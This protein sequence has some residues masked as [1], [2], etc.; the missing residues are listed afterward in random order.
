[1]EKLLSICIPVY[2]NADSLEILVNQIRQVTS[3]FLPNL[4][5]EI[6]FVDDG[7]TDKSWDVLLRLRDEYPNE[8]SIYKLSRNFGQLSAM[9]ASYEFA[10]GDALIS[11]SADLQ[12]PT[13]LIQQMV[14]EWSSGSDVVICF[15]AGRNDGLLFRISSK[16]AYSYA[17]RSTPGLPSGG[18]DYFLMSRRVAD[19]LI[20]LRGRFRF[21]QGDLLWMGFRA[22]YLPYTRQVRMH[23]K[24]GY[25]WSKRLR[26]FIDLVIDS[27][28]GPIQMMSRIGIFAAIA[29][30]AYLLTVIYS[31]AGGGTPFSGWAPIMVTLLI[32]NGIVMTML[33]IIGEYL[34]RIHDE[35]RQRPLFIVD[36]SKPRS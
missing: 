36:E 34:W 31:W 16:I 7:S 30:I 4:N 35:I 5:T 2:G 26:N 1:M 22:S 23:G 8:I 6:V 12:D 32:L 25:S 19:S 28:Y 14:D 29:G 13:E 21:I 10:K 20:S 11:M 18:F 17:K 33:G 24:S 3:N 9:L 27:S 15:R